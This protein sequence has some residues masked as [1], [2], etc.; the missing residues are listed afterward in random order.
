MS[1][2]KTVKLTSVDPKL[3]RVFRSEA[4]LR[5]CSM[6]KLFELLV[7]EMIVGKAVAA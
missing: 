2:A 5:G 1:E 3:V 6:S 7:T 4:A